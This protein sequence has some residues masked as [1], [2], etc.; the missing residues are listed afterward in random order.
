MLG[1]VL[2]VFAFNPETANMAEFYTT[3]ESNIFVHRDATESDAQQYLNVYATLPE[4]VKALLRKYEVNIYILPYTNGVEPANQTTSATAWPAMIRSTS[5][6][7]S[8]A[9]ITR[10]GWITCYTDLQPIYFA[11]EQLIY[12]VGQELNDISSYMHG[13]YQGSQYGFSE[14]FTTADG[15]KWTDIYKKDNAKKLQNVWHLDKLSELNW[16]ISAASGFA[17]A[18]RMYIC[19]GDILQEASSEVYDFMAAIIEHINIIQPVNDVTNTDQASIAEADVANTDQESIAET[20]PATVTDTDFSAQTSETVTQESETSTTLNEN[21]APISETENLTEE[22]TA[23]EQNNIVNNNIEDTPSEQSN[24]TDNNIEVTP[25]EPVQSSQ[26]IIKNK[27]KSA[28]IFFKTLHNNIEEQL[29]KIHVS[30]DFKKLTW[31]AIIVLIV[32]ATLL[33]AGTI[34]KN[35]RQTNTFYDTLN[36][37]KTYTPDEFTRIVQRLNGAE[38]QGAYILYNPITKEQ[39]HGV[40]D[41]TILHVQNILNDKKSENRVNIHRIYRAWVIKVIPLQKTPYKYLK[42]LNTKLGKYMRKFSNV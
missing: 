16:P 13:I 2:P 32:A 3:S 6:K 39:I 12:A 29:H 36:K 17:D 38:I 10:H 1:A 11:P 7:S 18:F 33:L 35:V 24:V 30:L 25:P 15:I 9:N 14:S 19:H 26:E 34:L 31:P 37:T 20:N 40:D 8:A 22:V 5:Q 41:K 23:A 21:A 27:E 28:D 4:S 42:P